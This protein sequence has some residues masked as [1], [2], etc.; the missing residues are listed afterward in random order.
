MQIIDLT[1]K[2][3]DQIISLFRTSKGSAKE[4]FSHFFNPLYNDVQI[5]H[6]NYLSSFMEASHILRKSIDNPK[7][8]KGNSNPKILAKFQKEILEAAV[9]LKAKRL[10]HEALR[11][12]ISCFAEIE[13][14]KYCYQS[15]ELDFLESAGQYISS[16]PLYCTSFDEAISELYINHDIIHARRFLDETIY[17]KRKKWDNVTKKYSK[18]ELRVWRRPITFKDYLNQILTKRKLLK[19]S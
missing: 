16:T 11:R 12:K 2:L 9:L 4:R 7:N 6:K 14:F 18:L 3:F 17:E 13:D 1:F 15:F 5:V 10:E 8:Y 19:R